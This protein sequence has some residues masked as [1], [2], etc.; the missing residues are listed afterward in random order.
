M[1][2]LRLITRAIADRV[3]KEILEPTI[4]AMQA[5]GTPFVGTLFLGLIFTKDGPKVIEYNARF[6]DPETQV[7]LPLLESDLA[8][9]LLAAVEGRLIPSL[10]KW[11]SGLTAV[12][13]VAASKGYPGSFETGKSIRGL[14]QIKGSIVFHAGTKL[15]NNGEILT[16]GGRVL[17]LVHINNN[18]AKQ[19]PG[20]TVI[21]PA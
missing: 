18:I 10:I 1:P 4:Q 13:V 12:C 9:I 6:G 21:W 8:A 11:R 2:R 16:A 3:Q 7:V 17:N 20:L 14:D 15:G 5:E 19:L